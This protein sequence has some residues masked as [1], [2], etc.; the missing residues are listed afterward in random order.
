MT[1]VRVSLDSNILVYAVLEPGSDK[2]RRAIEVVDRASP[3]GIL[4]TQALLEFVAVVRRRVPALTSKA[5]TQAQ[6][7]AAVFETATTTTKVAEA[8]YR[9]VAAHQ[10]Q[11]W[12]AVIWSAARMAG[13]TI[14][15]SEDLQDGLVLDGLRA[16][17]PFR[18][19]RQTLDTLLER[20]A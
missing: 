12:D 16:I 5:T 17:D 10:F 9:L 4:A 19:S 1:R 2:G 7:W 11:V 20:G 14:L 13:A 3:R 15:L 8:A 18:I 6:A